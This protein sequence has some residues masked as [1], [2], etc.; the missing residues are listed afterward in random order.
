WSNDVIDADRDAA[1]GRTDKP[2]AVG[3]IDRRL[4]MVATG[5]ALLATV[6][7]S[8]VLA[9]L[10]GVMAALAALLIVVCGWAYNLGV[11]STV[12]SFLPYVVAFGVLPAVATLALPSH[13]WPAW[14]AIA[15]GSMLGVAA[16]LVNVLPDLRQ[17]ALTGIRGLP[18]RIGATPSTIGAALLV[19]GAAAALL[20]GPAGAVPAWRWIAFGVLLAAGIG[21]A[22][23]VRRPGSRLLFSMLI[24]GAA[25]DVVLFAFSGTHLVPAS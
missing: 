4:T 12:L 10:G 6:V 13:P 21:T 20:F 18:H 16:H 25:I 14:W 11:R 1:V 9:V 24:V 3:S 5:V 23:V 22:A 8:A 2:L 15:A 19:V 7:L 17:D